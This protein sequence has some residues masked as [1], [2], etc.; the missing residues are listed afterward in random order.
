M[1]R[2]ANFI[3]TYSGGF[4]RAVNREFYQYLDS[5][6]SEREV[7][8]MNYGYVDANAAPTPLTAADEP[9]RRCIDLYHHVASGIDLA[10][11]DV[12]EVGS[13]R[14]GGASYV[15]RYHQPKTMTG[16]DYS[17]KAVAFC[18]E[19]HQ[20]EGLRYEHGDAENLPFEDASFDA[21]INVESSHCYAVM[22]RFLSE[23]N[24]VL[25][26][27]GHLL[28]ADLRSVSEVDDL[29]ADIAAT[30]FEVEKEETITPYVVN[31]MVPQGET[32]RA[33]I[34]R[35]VPRLVRPIFYHF[36]GIEGTHIYNQL[37][38]GAMTYL[39]MVLKK[40]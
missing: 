9:N 31:S 23:V 2:V 35:R 38:T 16:V 11:L 1:F 21:V 4:R 33:L 24:R 39:Y 28:W 32:N 13:G 18:R 25:R 27:G 26:P 15:K 40:G 3:S 12:L 6:D 17:S 8:F 30:G 7:I 14:G 19:K 10:G 37:A 29:R 5:V 36:A 22:A 20:V 34:D